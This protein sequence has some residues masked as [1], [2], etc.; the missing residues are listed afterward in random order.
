M[1]VWFCGFQSV[2]TILQQ[3]QGKP[4]QTQQQSAIQTEPNK[5]QQHQAHVPWSNIWGG[6]EAAEGKAGLG[7]VPTCARVQGE[8]MRR[9]QKE[10]HLQ[11]ALLYP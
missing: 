2:N 9:A 11:P 5:I 6:V 10:K 1:L 4:I 7:V 8:A 3:E